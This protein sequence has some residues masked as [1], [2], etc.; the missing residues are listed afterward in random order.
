MAAPSAMTST[1]RYLPGS[2][3]LAALLALLFASHLAQAAPAAIQADP[4][5]AVFDSRIWAQSVY[6]ENPAAN[7]SLD[8]DGDDL[9]CEDLPL[10]AAPALWTDAVPP[11]AIPVELAS[12]IDGDTVDVVLGGRLES[13]RM[14]GVDAPE[15]GG[16]YR[17]VECFGLEGTAYL[18]WLLSFDGQLFIEQDVEDR[19]QYGR[20]L[21]W[22]WFDLGNGEVYLLN[23][24]AIRA[25]HAERYRNTPNR[26]YVDELIEAEEFAQFYGLGLWGACDTGY[27]PVF[28]APPMIPPT[29]PPARSTAPLAGTDCDPAYPDICIPSPPPDL[30][31]RDVPYTRFR[32]LPPDPH[33]FDGNQDGVACEGPG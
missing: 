16:P 3:F 32:V 12:V 8:P 23:E 18:E 19:D 25:G 28:A 7:T 30:Q 14:V 11:A 27:V 20:L 24:A 2:V 26:R 33:N 22:V 29:A 15:T 31:C 5:C 4:A 13:V 10:G 9:A 17:E 21:R 1:P 6:D